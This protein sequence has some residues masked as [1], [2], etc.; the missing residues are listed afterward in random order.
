MANHQPLCVIP[1]G[2]IPPNNTCEQ[3]FAHLRAHGVSI[4][5][6]ATRPSVVPPGN[7]Y[8]DKGIPHVLITFYQAFTYAIRMTI[9]V[10]K[11]LGR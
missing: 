3:A 9:L 5:S 2:V 10:S 11:T 4:Q 7:T 8:E 6:Q 1:W